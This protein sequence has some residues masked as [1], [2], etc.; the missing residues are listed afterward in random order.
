MLKSLKLHQFS[1]GVAWNFFYTP[2]CVSEGGRSLKIL[3]K[4]AIFLVLISKKQI[5]PLLATLEKLL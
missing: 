5:L 4:Q 1:N 2:A 3:A